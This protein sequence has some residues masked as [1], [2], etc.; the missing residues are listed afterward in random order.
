MDDVTG[1]LQDKEGSLAM[2]TWRTS[3]KKGIPLQRNSD[4]R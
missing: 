2:R 1:G 4:A 3:L